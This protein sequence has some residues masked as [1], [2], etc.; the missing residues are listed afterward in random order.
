MAC[1]GRKRTPM[2][3]RTRVRARAINRP[4]G[5]VYWGI[6]IPRSD[7]ATQ[8]RT[9]DVVFARDRAVSLN[10]NARWHAFSRTFC[11]KTF[12]IITI[13]RLFRPRVAF[14]AQKRPIAVSA[15]AFGPPP[16]SARHRCKCNDPNTHQHPH[17]PRP[18]LTEF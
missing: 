9:Q 12:N 8:R 16:S 11:V 18:L 5:Q 6:M 17:T 1:E 3:R 7:A 15:G 10:R 4:S 14:S 13:M 2:E